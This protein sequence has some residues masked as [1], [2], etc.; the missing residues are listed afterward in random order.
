MPKRVLEGQVVSNV[1][2]KTVT[3]NV[4]RRI[5]DP[6]Y[7]KFVTKTRKFAAHDEKNEAGVG[8][9]VLIEE[10]APIS[11]S[12]VFKLLEIKTRARKASDI[13]DADTKGVLKKEKPAKKEEAVATEE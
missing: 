10:C 7:K 8:D 4:T 13:S 1:C 6:L 9:I 5:K 12:K 3:V 11:K 2:D